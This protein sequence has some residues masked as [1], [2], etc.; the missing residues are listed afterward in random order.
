MLKYFVVEDYPIQSAEIKYDY[1]FI[2]Y[3]LGFTALKRLK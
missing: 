2:K 1:E 3:H